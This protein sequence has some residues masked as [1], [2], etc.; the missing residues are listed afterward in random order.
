M[1]T[2]YLKIDP[3]LFASL[4]SRYG[5]CSVQTGLFKTGNKR[6]TVSS[7]MQ[8]RSESAI[9][10]NPKNANNMIGASKK[11]IDPAV[12]KFRLGVVY[13]FDAGATWHESQL[14][15][16]PEWDVM[17]DPAVAFDDFGNA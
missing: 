14:P 6:A 7:P 4:N 13:T 10:I 9:A 16:K 1:G 17:T 5:L 8:S 3:Q 2:E 15:L 12:Y 11:F